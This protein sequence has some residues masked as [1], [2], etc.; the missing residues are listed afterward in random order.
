[1]FL[2]HSVNGLDRVFGV[3]RVEMFGNFEMPRSQAA[4]ALGSPVAPV[5]STCKILRITM[6]CSL[7]VAREVAGKDLHDRPR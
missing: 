5:D 6:C 1:M 3:M 7:L 4:S 2:R